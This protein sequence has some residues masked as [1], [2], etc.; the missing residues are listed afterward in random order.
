[1]CG[2]ERVPSP[3]AYTRFLKRLVSKQAELETIYDRLVS[4]LC[5]ELEGFGEVLAIDSKALRSHGPPSRRDDGRD[6]STGSRTGRPPA[7]PGPTR[8]TAGTSS[9]P[10]PAS[11]GSIGP[12][13]G[14]RKTSTANSWSQAPTTGCPLRTSNPRGT[15]RR[16]NQLHGKEA[17]KCPSRSAFAALFV[18]ASCS[19][20]A[21]TRTDF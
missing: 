10:R 6:S 4:E 15:S 14:P 1:M 20:R 3:A 21:R 8:S 2:L 18:T 5:G 9:R 7:A 16:N 19:T 12:G 17:L 11:S 13:S